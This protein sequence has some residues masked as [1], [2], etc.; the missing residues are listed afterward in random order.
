MNISEQNAEDVRQRYHTDP[1]FHAVT[2]LLSQGGYADENGVA[3]EGPTMA[4]AQR[5]ARL[6]DGLAANGLQIG[7]LIDGGGEHG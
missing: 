2:H 4:D 6:I 7:A 5:A 1:I 3:Y